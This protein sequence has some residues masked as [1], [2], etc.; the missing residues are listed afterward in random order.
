MGDLQKSAWRTEVRCRGGSF[1][2][3]VQDSGKRVTN[4]VKNDM[5]RL[6]VS[7]DLI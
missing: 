1:Y 4:R 5:V 6:G 2:I 3:L 7:I